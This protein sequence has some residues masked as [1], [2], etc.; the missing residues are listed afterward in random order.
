MRKIVRYVILALATQR[1]TRLIVD[2]KIMKRPRQLIFDRNNEYLSYLVTCVKCVSIWAA[3]VVSVL[4]R[5]GRSRLRGRSLTYLMLDTLA[6][7][8]ITI[9]AD[10]IARRNSASMFD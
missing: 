8:E 1:L 7:S 3:I 4:D 9:I 5:A 10:E 2:D 6:L